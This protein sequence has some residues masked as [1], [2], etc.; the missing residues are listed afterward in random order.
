[1]ES[2]SSSSLVEASKGLLSMGI[3]TW[4]SVRGLCGGA[5][6]AGATG[7]S[8]Q[9][10]AKRSASDC[11]GF[12]TVYDC[13]APDEDSIHLSTSLRLIAR[14]QAFTEDLELLRF[15]PSGT[16]VASASVSGQTVL[17]HCVCPPAGLIPGYP[18]F[19]A[20]AEYS[21]RIWSQPQSSPNSGWESSDGPRTCFEA[22]LLY[23]L[24]R[25]VIWA[26][27]T[28]VCMDDLEKFALV[29]SSNGTV[30][31]FQMGR[32]ES[33][34]TSAA[35]DND[36]G[37]I[38]PSPFVRD[39]GKMCQLQPS[40]ASSHSK[41]RE[42]AV[43]VCRVRVA[44]RPASPVAPLNIQ[45][46]C[47]QCLTPD[48]AGGMTVF[49]L[50]VM[51]LS[52][53]GLLSKYI[54]TDG[55]IG[56]DLVEDR[57]RSPPTVPDHWRAREVGR[58]DFSSF[59]SEPPGSHPVP[60]SSQEMRTGRDGTTRLLVEDTG[61]LTDT[62]HREDVF[63]SVT[64]RSRGAM[65]W[66]SASSIA[67]EP[68]ELPFWL[69]PNVSVSQVTAGQTHRN[70]SETQNP[71]GNVGNGHLFPERCNTIALA[72]HRPC[73]IVL[74]NLRPEPSTGPETVG[75]MTTPAGREA[76]VSRNMS[77]ALKGRASTTVSNK[78]DFSALHDVSGSPDSV[79]VIGGDG[80]VENAALQAVQTQ[81]AD[82]SRTAMC[83]P[84]QAPTHSTVTYGRG[85]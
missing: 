35:R 67:S 66:L 51:A 83:S 52:S 23:R 15:S 38:S 18:N 85:I 13:P 75:E 22:V 14:Y 60:T 42:E 50:E 7:N 57:A 16:R 64:D 41:W 82:A 6:P 28:D 30:H 74:S 73:P 81:I 76:G 84:A 71:A 2:F 29:C 12:V 17:I 55:A 46:A 62:V 79:V 25:G 58:W 65:H 36:V 69:L 56:S 4:S 8:S 21:G 53:E 34:N 37:G 80:E 31:V 10:P 24:V 68:A 63:Y 3:S 32:S 33:T 19:F 9:T 45:A 47:S 26:S 20:S 27:I 44:L 72:V 43:R 61:R 49:G 78:E 54:L 11:G 59:N 1:M 40:A 77:L 48:L 39:V 5:S 70:Q